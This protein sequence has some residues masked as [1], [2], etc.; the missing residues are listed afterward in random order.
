MIIENILNNQDT[1]FGYDFGL[2]DILLTTCLDWAVAYKFNLPW[3]VSRYHEAA[4]D[5]EAY[6]IAF[7]I[8]YKTKI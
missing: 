4:R 3:N 1:L 8:N 5:R 6:K 7:D 2:A